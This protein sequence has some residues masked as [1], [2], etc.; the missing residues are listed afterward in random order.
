IA[1]IIP[2]TR[3][4]RTLLLVVVSAMVLSTLFTYLPFISEHISSGFRIIIITV[5]VSAVAAALSPI[6]EEEEASAASGGDK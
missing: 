2:N 1:I 6:K 3:T 4:N 5:V